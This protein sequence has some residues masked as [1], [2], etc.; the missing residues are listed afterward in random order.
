MTLKI[1]DSMMSCLKTF[2]RHHCLQPVFEKLD[3]VLTWYIV[4]EL[5][6]N[7]FLLLFN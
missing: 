2:N 6:D 4:V 5:G 3:F 1:L 7:C